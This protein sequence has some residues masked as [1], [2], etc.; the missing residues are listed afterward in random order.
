MMENKRKET[1]KNLSMLYYTAKRYPVLG[2]EMLLGIDL[3]F[4]QKDIL[5]RLWRNKRPM[6]LCSRRTGKTFTSA[7]YFALK[8]LLYEDIKIGITAPVFRQAQT[9][10]N[11]VEKIYKKSPLFMAEVIDRPKHGSTSWLINLKNGSKIEAL[12]LNPNIRSKGYNIVMVDE[13]GFPH[14]GSMNEM[15]DQILKPMLFTKRDGVEEDETDIGNQLIIAST[16]SFTW[17]DYYKQYQMYQD[18]IAEGNEDY[19]IITYDFIDGLKGGKFENDMVL[20]EYY[21]ADPI[22]RKMEYLN[23]FP[24]DTGGFISYKLLDERAIDH[25]K[26]IDEEK[27][28]Y[29]VPKT[30]IEFEQEYDEDGI[31]NHKYILAFDDADQGQDNF[32]AAVIKLDGNKKRLVRMVTMNQA[33]IKEKIK[34]VRDIM[35]KF[36]IVLIVADQRNKNIKDG[37]AEP[38]EYDDGYVGDIIIDKDDKEQLKYVQKKY[39]DEYQIR[40]LLQIHNFTNSTNEERARHFLSEIEKGRF[41]IP[42]DPVTGYKS[43]KE[44]KAYQEIK[45]TIYEITAIKIKA[46]NNVVKYIPEDSRQTKDRWTVCEL[47][48]YMADEMIKDTYKRTPSDGF[49]LGKWSN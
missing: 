13:Y 8:A 29:S 28:K 46:Y 6:L 32:A 2:A 12:P 14:N 15:V 22:T 20:E 17:N 3:T 1:L 21:N 5:E 31:P 24:D 27:G 4:Y 18:K 9:V 26:L 35:R 23:I 33:F 11:E 39:G 44:E 42:A 47:G 37:L 25:P 40:K 43:K 19:D 36:N 10:F 38:Y 49:T 34:V 48:C 30:Q 45:N 7:V 16:A 41:K